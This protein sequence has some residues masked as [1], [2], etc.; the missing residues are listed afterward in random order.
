M[1]DFSYTSPSSLPRCRVT[2]SVH[3]P[4]VTQNDILEAK[5]FDKIP[6]DYSP[7]WLREH[8]EAAAESTTVV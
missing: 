4:G 6:V 2:L 8:P 7:K 1:H 3:Q 5:L